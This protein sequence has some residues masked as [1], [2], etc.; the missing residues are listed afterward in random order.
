MRWGVRDEM[1][2]EHL[3]TSLCMKELKSCQEL[4]I[5]EKEDEMG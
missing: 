5:G 2:N 3:T 4:S 1:T